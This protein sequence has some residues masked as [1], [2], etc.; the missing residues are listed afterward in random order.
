MKATF[1]SY[2]WVQT[3]LNDLE[4]KNLEDYLHPTPLPTFTLTHNYYIYKPNGLIHKANYK[5]IETIIKHFKGQ[6]TPLASANYCI[7]P[8]AIQPKSVQL[9][10]HKNNNIQILR[11][12][13][14]FE[15]IQHAKH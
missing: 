8:K 11:A 13:W 2:E 14:L 15:T 10:L 4:E 6:I 1:I 3:T 7:I 5:Y 12:Q 9:I